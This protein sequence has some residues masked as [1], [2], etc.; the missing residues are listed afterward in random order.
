MRLALQSN[1]SHLID[2]Y[3]RGRREEKERS[4]EK[5]ERE[6]V[7]RIREKDREIYREEERE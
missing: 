2:E 6:R 5:K 3:D 4:D 1:T 7:K